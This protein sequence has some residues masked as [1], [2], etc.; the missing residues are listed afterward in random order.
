M[1]KREGH[2][3]GSAHSKSSGIQRFLRERNLIR[4]YGTSISLHTLR[5]GERNRENIYIYFLTIA[6]MIVMFWAPVGSAPSLQS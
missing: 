2:H 1:E 4:Y 6:I 3:A 5:N